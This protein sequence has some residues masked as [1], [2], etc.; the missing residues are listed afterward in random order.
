MD[1]C[2]NWLTN[3][4]NGNKYNFVND[5]PFLNFNVAFV[6]AIMIIVDAKSTLELD[7]M[8]L[9]C[10]WRSVEFLMSYEGIDT[11]LK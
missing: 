11:F 8:L 3:L 6:G 7:Q 1:G 10:L 9:I 5:S 4:V 2:I